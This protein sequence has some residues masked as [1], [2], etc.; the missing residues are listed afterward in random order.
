MRAEPAA[1]S[2]TERPTAIEAAGWAA[3]AAL[4]VAI[5]LLALLRPTDPRSI[6]HEIRLAAGF[7][8]YE[9]AMGEGERIYSTAAGE[10][11]WRGEDME[12]EE[13]EEIHAMFAHA[14]ERFEVARRESEGFYEDQRAQVALAKVYYAWARDLLRMADRPWY[15]RNDE[16]ILRRAREIVDRGL[17]LPNV[18][19]SQRV[20]LERLGT[21]IDRAITPWPIL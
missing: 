17:A 9:V 21:Q 19:G 8:R 18:T 6:L 15:R 2:P 13:R 11:R 7:D 16:P 3:L 20:A 12:P 1:A 5:G 14:A 10:L 4:T